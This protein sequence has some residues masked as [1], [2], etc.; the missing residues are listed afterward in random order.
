LLN[1]H[2]FIFENA[3]V[4]RGYGATAAAMLAIAMALLFG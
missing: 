1:T 2:D 3:R 4:L